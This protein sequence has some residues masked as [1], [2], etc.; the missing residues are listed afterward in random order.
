MAKYP[1]VDLADEI[2]ATSPL[3]INAIPQT[4]EEKSVSSSLASSHESLASNMSWEPEVSTEL[5]STSRNSIYY[6]CSSE[7]DLLNLA[8]LTADKRSHSIGYLPTYEWTVTD[9]PLDDI[10]S[11]P[12]TSNHENENEINN[13]QKSSSPNYYKIYD[14]DED[15]DDDH[16]DKNST[17][18]KPPPESFYTLVPAMTPIH[19]K[20]TFE[21]HL[22]DHWDNAIHTSSQG[23]STTTTATT[24]VSAATTVATTRKVA[25][26]K[27]SKLRTKHVVERTFSNSKRNHHHHEQQRLISGKR[28]QRNSPPLERS[29]SWP[30][31]V[32]GGEDK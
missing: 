28:L 15:E 26:K 10:S 5:L 11:V 21:Q 30:S 31:L 6:R 14:D 13:K 20:K 4:A 8:P 3:L 9:I 12:T 19:G 17:H 27:Q 16:H 22:K 2:D 29:S 32:S 25:Y 18:I 7:A 24:T 23:T 1:K